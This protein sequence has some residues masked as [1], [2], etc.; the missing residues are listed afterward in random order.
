MIR[1]VGLVAREGHSVRYSGRYTCSVRTGVCVVASGAAGGACLEAFPAGG[2]LAWRCQSWVS[3]TVSI[4]WANKEYMHSGF[5]G[6]S[7]AARDLHQGLVQRG[8]HAERRTA[9]FDRVWVQGTV[10]AAGCCQGFWET[11]GKGQGG[12]ALRRAEK[13][14]R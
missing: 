2:R 12:L 4:A 7:I 10:S 9:V 8:S 5:L 3:G 1:M 11:A 13:V 6:S 14:D